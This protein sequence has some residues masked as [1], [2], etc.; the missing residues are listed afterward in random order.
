ML[1]EDGN[2]DGEN[3]RANAREGVWSADREAKIAANQKKKE[4]VGQA[5]GATA[6]AYKAANAK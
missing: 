4:E 5:Y 6:A 3:E 2:G 1:R